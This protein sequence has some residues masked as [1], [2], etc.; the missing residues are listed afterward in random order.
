V[1]DALPLFMLVIIIVALI[2]FTIWLNISTRKYKA[3]LTPEE[4][5]EY[6]RGSQRLPGDW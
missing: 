2:A 5:A 1:N 4:L 3:T 6:E